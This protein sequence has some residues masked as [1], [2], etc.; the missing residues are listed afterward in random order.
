MFIKHICLHFH[1]LNCTSA[2]L[3]MPNSRS[4]S[5][6]IFSIKLLHKI[7]QSDIHFLK[8]F[9]SLNIF[10]VGTVDQNNDMRELY[11]S[12]RMAVAASGCLCACATKANLASERGCLCLCCC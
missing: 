4:V 3:F 11:Y 6:N 9:H 8:C 10:Q 5:F 12:T 1:S 7:L 2:Q